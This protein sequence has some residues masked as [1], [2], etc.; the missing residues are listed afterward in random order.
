MRQEFSEENFEMIE[1]YDKEL[2][3]FSIAK[4]TRLTHLKTLQSITRLLN[5]DWKDDGDEV[6]FEH[7]WIAKSKEDRPVKIPCMCHASLEYVAVCNKLFPNCLLI[8]D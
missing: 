4:S 5:K 2:V 6:I 7:Y 1:K 3:R 8:F